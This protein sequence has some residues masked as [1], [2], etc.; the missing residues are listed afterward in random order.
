MRRCSASAV[1]Y[2]VTRRPAFLFYQETT[3]EL[4]NTNDIMDET[5]PV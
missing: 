3:I 4:L 2:C 1:S 5:V